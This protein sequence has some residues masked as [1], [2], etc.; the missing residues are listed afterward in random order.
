MAPATPAASSS[1][2]RTDVGFWH[3]LMRAELQRRGP[4]GRGL[5]DHDHRR[6]AGRRGRHRPA[7][8]RPTLNYWFRSEH[9]P[10]CAN[11]R[12]IFAQAAPCPGS[13]TEFK[14][15]CFRVT[16]RPERQLVGGSQPG[17]PGSGRSSRLPENPLY[18]SAEINNPVAGRPIASHRS[19]IGGLWR[20]CNTLMKVSAILVA[21]SLPGS[22]ERVTGDLA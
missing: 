19:S 5:A 7:R 13:A 3:A 10:A 1:W 14:K 22:G 20:K 17:A 9:F 11:L 16:G 6:R 2:S 18:C 12:A 8:R 21:V 15:I 4:P